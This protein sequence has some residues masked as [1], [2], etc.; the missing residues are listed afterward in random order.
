[1]ACEGLFYISETDAVI[2]AFFRDDLKEPT[3]NELLRSL[4]RADET[5]TESSNPEDFFQR[6]TRGKEWHTK[7]QTRAVSR[8]KKLQKLLE[9]ELR[10]IHVIRIGRIRIEIYVIGKSRNGE[11]AGIKT[12]AVE[13]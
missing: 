7:E 3:A 6:L 10:N 13:T 5:A 9:K 12:L 8:F 1:V 11:V 2:E 4:E